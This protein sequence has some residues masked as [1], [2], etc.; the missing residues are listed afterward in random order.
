MV[1]STTQWGTTRCDEAVRRGSHKSVHLHREFVF[2][3]MLDFCQQGYW[4]V[5]PYALV[6][7]WP[8]LRVSPLGAVPQRDRRPQL[9]VDYSYS[10]VNQETVQLAPPEAMQFG[11]TLQQVLSR[12][13]HADARYSPVHLSKIDIANG[14]YR[15]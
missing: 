2:D 6:Q 15:V 10:G 8:E 7:Q 5:L 12:I 4:L 13:V 14:F 3:E 9:I 11:R 1:T